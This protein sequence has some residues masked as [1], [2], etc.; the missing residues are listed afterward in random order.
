MEVRIEICGKLGRLFYTYLEIKA[1][2]PAYSVLPCQHEVPSDF[3]HVHVYVY[4]VTNTFSIA[5]TSWLIYSL[6]VNEKL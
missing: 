3:Q 4:Y 6:V 5:F 2:F 1:S